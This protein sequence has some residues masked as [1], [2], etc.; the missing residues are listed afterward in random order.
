MK[1]TKQQ[2]KEVVDNLDGGMRCFYNLKSGVIKILS[3][4][5]NMMIADEEL[6]EEE[7][8][9]LDRNWDDY[10]EFEALTSRESFLIMADFVDMVDDQILQNKLVNALNRPK[11]FRN[12]KYH[13]D[14]SGAYR[15]KWFDYKEMRY[16]EA[17][18]QQIEVY[19]KASDAE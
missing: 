2:I 16:I 10:F 15:Q 13:I 8:E 3:N 12:F 17:V 11:P 6:W 7:I 19:N 9:E 14:D 1:L 18:K 5:E 4:Y